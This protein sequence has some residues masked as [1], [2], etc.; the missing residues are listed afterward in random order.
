MDWSEVFVDANVDHIY[1]T[2]NSIVFQ[3]S[4]ST[5]GQFGNNLDTFWHVYD[6]GPLCSKHRYLNINATCPGK[7]ALHSLSVTVVGSE[8]EGRDGDGT[9]VGVVRRYGEGPEKRR[10]GGR[11][12]I[13]RVGVEQ[14]FQG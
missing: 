12:E 4:K 3:F 14:V 1:W 11:W 7:W 5:S 8:G 6:T 10:G 13:R 9:A 2:S